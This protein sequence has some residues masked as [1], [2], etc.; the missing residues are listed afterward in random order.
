MSTVERYQEQFEELRNR[1]LF[2]NSH[3]TEEHLISCYINGLKEDLVPFMD[4]AHPNT[5]LEA[6]EQATLHDK[7]LSVINRKFR[8]N[9]R[10]PLY[11]T[12]V[13]PRQAPGPLTPKVWQ[14]NFQNSAGTQLP[15]NRALIEQ[16][17]AAGQCFKCGERY[18]PGHVCSSKSLNILQGLDDILESYYEVCI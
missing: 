9:V 4:I 14:N 7:A 1:L 3:L 5:L 6:Y 8:G 11:Q 16:M 15:S 18:H 2:Y 17:R 10:N 13:Y 12:L